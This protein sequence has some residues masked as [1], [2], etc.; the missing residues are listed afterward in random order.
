MKYSISIFSYLKKRKKEKK[1]KENAL[2][3]INERQVKE[4]N[5]R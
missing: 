5:G 4:L 2:Y 3:G 1:K